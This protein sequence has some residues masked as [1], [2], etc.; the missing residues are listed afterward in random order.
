VGGLQ[1][2]RFAVAG[3]QA[4]QTVDLGTALEAEVLGH[5]A[6]SGDRPGVQD[7]CAGLQAEGAHFLAERAQAALAGPVAEHLGLEGGAEVHRLRRLRT[8][9][10]KPIGLQTAHLPVTRF[11]GLADKLAGGASL[12]QVLR[13]EYGVELDHARETFSVVR[14]PKG[15]AQLL[16]TESGEP[17]FHVERVAYDATG[18][19]EYTVSVMRG[20]RYRIQWILRTGGPALEPIQGDES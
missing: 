9:D 19:F 12:Y 1:A 5:R 3:A 6:A 8:G 13:T 11:P 17:A 15:A 18:P 14:I 2:D 4:P 10:G 16:G 20:D 7:A